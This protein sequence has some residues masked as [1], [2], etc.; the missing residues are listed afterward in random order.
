VSDARPAAR[1]G[2]PAAELSVLDRLLD[3]APDRPREA[4]PSALAVR[5]RLCRAVHRDVEALL[6]ARRPWRSVPAALGELRV[7]PLGYGMADATA[8]SF[9]DRAQRDLVRADIEDALRRFEPRLEQVQVRLI[10]D[11]SL[12]RA[13]LHLRIDALLRLQPAP[14]PIAFD[15]AFD[16][17]SATVTLSPLH[18]S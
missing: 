15:T 10:D 9:N 14:E 6:N 16:I 8:G 2:R 11:D 13:T 7:S 18:G 4:P 17:T 12:L 3:S 1:R 5:E